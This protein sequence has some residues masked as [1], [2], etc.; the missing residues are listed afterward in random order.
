VLHR[1][2]GITRQVLARA[3]G[4]VLFVL[5]ARDC[6]RQADHLGDDCAVI[7]DAA[8]EVVGAVAGLELERI[9]PARQ[10]RRLAVVDVAGSST[11]TTSW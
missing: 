11:T 8:A 9:D 10:R 6:A 2:V 5:H 3:G 7:A 4:E 1:H